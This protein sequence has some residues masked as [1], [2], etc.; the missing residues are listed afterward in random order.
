MGKAF[1]DLAHPTIEPAASWNARIGA[2]TLIEL[3][4]VMVIIAT[5]LTVALP[6]YFT[7]IDRSK[8]VALRQNLNVMRDAIDKYQGDLGIFPETLDELVNK[9]YLR[10]IPVDPITESATTWQIV[11]PPT[12]SKK[13]GV[14]D[15]KSGA[16]GKAL[17]GT[18]FQD[19]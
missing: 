1:G 10:A 12:D 4:V 3:L 16:A 7:S 13:T 8:E 18:D 5:L 14:Y 17:N 2:F 19:W 6:R 9:K 11:P 15:V